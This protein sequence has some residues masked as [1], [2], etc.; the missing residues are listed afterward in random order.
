MPLSAQVSGMMLKAAP[1]VRTLQTDRTIGFVALCS[2]L[3]RLCQASMTRAAISTGS[4]A[5]DGNAPCPPLPAIVHCQL[6]RK[7]MNAPG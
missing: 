6:S 7:D 4:T 1:G 3:T 5:S 2:R